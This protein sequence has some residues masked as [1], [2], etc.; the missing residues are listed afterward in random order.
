MELI[1]NGNIVRRDLAKLGFAW[2]PCSAWSLGPTLEPHWH[3]LCA[4]WDHLEPDRFLAQGAMFRRR[5][6][7]RYRWAPCNRELLPLPA[8]PYFQPEP[9]NA[10]A[11]GIIR[12]FAPLRAAT[13]HNPLLHAM[14]RATF[15]CLPLAVEKAS[16]TWEVR[17]HQIRIT[18]SALEM[19]LPAPEGIHQG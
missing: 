1:T 5:R 7:G 3:R 10:Y 2:V 9:E 12:E 14:V 17:I 16:A 15:A 8:K 13:V 18:A 19:G 6:Y 11:G 4:D